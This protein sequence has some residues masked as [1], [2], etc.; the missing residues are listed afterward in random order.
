VKG[1][2]RE[3][4]VRRPPDRPYQSQGGVKGVKEEKGK[5]KEETGNKLEY[6]VRRISMYSGRI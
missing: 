1:V 5:R 3:S 6:G 2:K 4:K